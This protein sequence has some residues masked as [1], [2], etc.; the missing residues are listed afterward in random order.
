[1]NELGEVSPSA[2][3]QVGTYCDPKKLDLVV[4]LGQD[5][6][7]HLAPAAKEGGCEVHSYLDAKEAGNFVKS[8]LK[9]HAIVLAK[10]SQNG[11]FAEES[12]KPLLENKDDE[13]RLVRQSPYWLSVKQLQD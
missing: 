11:V 13:A 5:A 6:K 10:G 2:H 7:D 1:M 3:A 8:K 9:N 4:T 12:L